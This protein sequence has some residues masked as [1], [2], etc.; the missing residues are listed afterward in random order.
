MTQPCSYVNFEM[1]QAV[2]DMMPFDAENKM[3]NGAAVVGWLL[4]RESAETAPPFFFTAQFL[5]LRNFS[6]RVY[7]KNLFHF[8]YTTFDICWQ[9]F[10]PFFLIFLR[11]MNKGSF[12]KYVT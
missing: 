7:F 6:G 4:F 12:K 11:F 9:R 1:I 8:S 10:S 5:I 2:V 3:R